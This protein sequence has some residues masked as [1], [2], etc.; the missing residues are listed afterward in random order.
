MLEDGVLNQEGWELR[1]EAGGVRQGPAP[2]LS[3][4]PQLPLP[5][6][7][8]AGAESRLHPDPGPA[9]RLPASPRLPAAPRGRW[10]AGLS[11]SGS[12]P[13]TRSS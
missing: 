4:A 1:A 12:T 10:A 13:L 11:L 3:H 7:L 9:P 5:P 6:V 2:G 8:R